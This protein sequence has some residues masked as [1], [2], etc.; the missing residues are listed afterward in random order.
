MPNR[1]KL[2]EIGCKRCGI[3]KLARKSNLNEEKGN[4]CGR[5]CSGLVAAE[6]NGGF[7][8]RAKSGKVTNCLKTGS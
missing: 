5:R 4:Y 8:L 6:R 7:R 3:R 1:H 2:V